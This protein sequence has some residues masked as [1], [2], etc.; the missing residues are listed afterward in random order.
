MPVYWV[1]DPR[2][3]LRLGG[4]PPEYCGLPTYL[5]TYLPTTVLWGV[6]ALTG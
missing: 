5:P 6:T 3:L 1:D 4:A 2:V